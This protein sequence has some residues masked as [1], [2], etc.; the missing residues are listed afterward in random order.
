V[1]LA[2]CWAPGWSQVCGDCNG[3]QGVTA[4]DALLA[5]LHAVD[6]AGL[7][8]ADFAGCDVNADERVTVIDSLLIAQNAVGLGTALTCLPP[9][10]E[11]VLLDPAPPIGVSGYSRMAYDS[12]RAETVVFQMGNTYLWDGAVWI[13]PPVVTLPPPRNDA[14]LVNDPVRGEVL[15]LTVSSTLCPVVPLETWAWDGVDWHQKTPSVVP[16][17]RVVGAAVFDEVRQEV[18][19]FGG[20]VICGAET[21]ETWLWDGVDWRQ[22]LPAASPPPRSSLAMG[23]DAVSQGVLVFG[24]RP[25]GSGSA[26]LGDTWLWDGSDWTEIVLPSPDRPGPRWPCDLAPM[27]NGRLMLF[28]GGL[29]GDDQTWEWD[30]SRWSRK[31]PEVHPSRRLGHAITYDE[32]RG[33]VLLLGGQEAWPQCCMDLT[34]F[35]AR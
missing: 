4:V 28:G 12:A 26:S 11:W 34:D 6:R 20:S 31:Y 7:T 14:V 19:M 5:A 18:V 16:L 2:L 15:L 8:G 32:A 13:T 9:P 25:V 17:G 29:L 24:G 35:W 1:F 10:L 22:A 27:A 21:D 30:G 33:V 3:D 23:W